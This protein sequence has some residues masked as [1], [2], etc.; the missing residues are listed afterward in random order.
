MV[1]DALR[2]YVMEEYPEA[3]IEYEFHTPWGKE[4][5]FLPHPDSEEDYSCVE[6]DGKP[7]ILTDF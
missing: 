1:M 2:R 5:L 7:L 3:V 6:M 4:I